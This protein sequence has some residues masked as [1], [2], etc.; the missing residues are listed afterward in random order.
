MYR[1]AEKIGCG[2]SLLCAMYGEVELWAIHIG[3]LPPF[4]PPSKT[5]P[6]SDFI[7]IFV[8]L[9]FWEILL[10]EFGGP[11]QVFT[12]TSTMSF[13][14]T[15][16]ILHHRI[17]NWSILTPTQQIPSLQVYAWH[18]VQRNKMFY[19]FQ[20]RQWAVPWHHEVF[21]FIPLSR[22]LFFPAQSISV[23]SKTQTPSNQLPLLPS[24]CPILPDPRPPEQ[25]NLRTSL[26]P[27]PG[28]WRWSWSCRWVWC[29][30]DVT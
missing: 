28:Y 18:Q 9:H 14:R 5:L 23:P 12:L 3:I 19:F 25:E 16:T 15:T 1:S 24:I 26:E 27:M 7:A 13:F 17:Q 10:G 21:L 29:G 4:I 8:Y 11:S 30:M 20:R 6:Y 2:A 22:F